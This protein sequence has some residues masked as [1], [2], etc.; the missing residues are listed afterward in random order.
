MT[1]EEIAGTLTELFGTSSVGTLAQP[2]VEIAPGSWQ[3]D[4]SVFRLL[5]LLSEDNTWLR[6]LLPIVPIQEAQPFLEQFLEA[7]FDDTQEVRYA[8]F[9]GVIYGVFQHNSSTLVGAD[10]SNAINRLVSLHEA[11]L[12]NVFNRLIESRIRQIIQ[13]A[14]QQ[15]QSLQAT[16]QTLERFYAEGLMGEINQSSEAQEEVLVAWRRQLERL[17]NE[18]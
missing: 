3:V 18:V 17:W 16:M 13:A 12:D 7:N 15:G 11:G 14:K 8:L 4:T 5:V 6:V 10:L 1:P 2:V 9:E